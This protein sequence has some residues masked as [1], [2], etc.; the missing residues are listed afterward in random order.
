MGGWMLSRDPSL[1]WTP[2]LKTQPGNIKI[3]H[4]QITPGWERVQLLPND[5]TGVS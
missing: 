1:R 4:R 2:Q 3:M 5:E